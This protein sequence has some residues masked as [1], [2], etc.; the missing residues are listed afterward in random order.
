MKTILQEKMLRSMDDVTEV[1]SMSEVI[2]EL[3]N[4]GLEHWFLTGIGI[5]KGEYA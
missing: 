2:K 4:A 5:R 3:D 1:E